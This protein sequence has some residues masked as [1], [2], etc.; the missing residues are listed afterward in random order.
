MTNQSSSIIVSRSVGL[1][2]LLLHLRTHQQINNSH[3][4]KVV[5]C[6]PAAAAPFFLTLIQVFCVCVCVWGDFGKRPVA[7]IGRVRVCFNK[8]KIIK[9][10]FVSQNGHHD[11]TRHHRHDDDD[12]QQQL[13]DPVSVL[14]LS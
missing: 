8:Q 13:I 12:L 1:L 7:V 2:L 11:T 3:K 5:T 9:T 6:A 14:L 4:T 10:G